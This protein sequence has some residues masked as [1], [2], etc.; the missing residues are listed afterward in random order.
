M[1]GEKVVHPGSEDRPD[2]ALLGADCTIWVVH[3]STGEYS[4]RYE[5]SVKAFVDEE[6][7]K[8]YVL[9]LT[10]E[11]QKLPTQDW[12]TRG[13]VER[14]MR[15]ID[16]CFSED[17]TGTHWFVSSVPLSLRLFEIPPDGP[18]GQ[19]GPVSSPGM[20]NN[21]HPGEGQ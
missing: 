1:S 8:N 13:E 9:F 10:R 11:R 12:D 21:S 4:D 16:P 17:Y 18:K 7:A 15:A 5:W 19:D 3:G 14:L 2:A 6:S 20:T